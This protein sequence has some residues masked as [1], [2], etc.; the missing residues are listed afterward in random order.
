MHHPQR[1]FVLTAL[2]SLALAG[3]VWAQASYPEKPINFVVPFA[4]ASAT[5]S[6]ARA[7][8]QS[9]TEQTGQPV[10]ADNR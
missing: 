9:I 7:L 8:G 2:A 6:L 10:V 5:D 3:P 1:R 4:A